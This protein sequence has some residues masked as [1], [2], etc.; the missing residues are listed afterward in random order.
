[1]RIVKHA[2]GA[3]VSEGTSNMGR[4]EGIGQRLVVLMTT[5]NGRRYL[6]AQLESIAAQQWP[7]IDLVVSD[8]GSTDGTLDVLRRWQSEWTKGNLDLRAGPRTGFAAN[9]RS[10]IADPRIDAEYIAFADQDDIWDT[11]KTA[12][13]VK[14]LST[15]APGK[16][17]LYCSRTRLID[18][19]GRDIGRSPLFVRPPSFRNSI[20][21]SIGG[22]N[23][24][25]M[26]RSA[27]EALSESARRTSFVTHDWWTYILVTGI[28]GIV[29]Y[30]PVP[31]VGY[32]QH[33]GNQIGNNMSLKAKLVRAYLL[34]EGRFAAWNAT[35]LAALSMCDD[36]LEEEAKRIVGEFA[37]IRQKSL[38]RRLRGLHRLGVYRQTA[39]SNIALYVAA[40]IGKI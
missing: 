19:E 12:A 21:Q 29:V 32:R 20:V 14:A 40:M 10:L 25:L 9:F 23:T 33:S 13:A 15:V 7:A 30:D 28:G 37:S 18:E 1:M 27:F 16:P 36:L 3:A 4:E 11:D 17:A 26:N 34:L 2:G 24:M 38:R 31:H 6:E 5:F 22:G 35:N 8:D 39:L